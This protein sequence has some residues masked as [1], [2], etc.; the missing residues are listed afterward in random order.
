MLSKN[1]SFSLC[2]VAASI[3]SFSCI[4]VAEQEP[5]FFKPDLAKT[6]G[7]MLMID[8]DI[9]HKFEENRLLGAM[10]KKNASTATTKF[11]P[12]MQP[13]QATPEAKPEAAINVE[14]VKETPPILLGIFGISENLYAD[15]QIDNERV[16]FQRGRSNPISG[17]LK[18]NYQLISINVPCVALVKNSKKT[19]VCLE[20]DG[21]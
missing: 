17:S 7:Q 15:V 14:V 21:I 12:V 6:V 16:R 11:A 4:A 9:A 13:I 5:S 1:K 18:G 20:K 2:F 19:S 10:G 8:A 3:F